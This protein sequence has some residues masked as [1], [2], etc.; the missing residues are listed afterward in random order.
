[1][2]EPSVFDGPENTLPRDT[3][4]YLDSGERL[5]SKDVKN[6][7]GRMMLEPTYDGLKERN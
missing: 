4:F 7:Y 1:M 3:R 2:N 5:F 6:S